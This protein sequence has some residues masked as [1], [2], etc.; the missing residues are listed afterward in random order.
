M[1]GAFTPVSAAPPSW[2]IGWEKLTGGGGI[3]SVIKE[4]A[5]QT[6]QANSLDEAVKS[7]KLA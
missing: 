6:N 1:N 4:I 3:V 7:F 5:D 2:S